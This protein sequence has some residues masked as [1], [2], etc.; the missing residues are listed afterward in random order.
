MDAR[1]RLEQ[2]YASFAPDVRAYARRR[3]HAEAVDDVVADVFVV[4]WRKIDSVPEEALPW[5][6]GVAR[7]VVGNQLR[8][9]HRR[10][11]LTERLGDQPAAAAAEVESGEVLRAL[12]SLSPR[13]REV[14]MLIAWEGL[15]QREA[16]AAMDCSPPVFRVRLFRAR[17]K[18]EHALRQEAADP[19]PAVEGTRTI[20][21]FDK[22]GDLS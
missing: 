8:S 18:L 21:V 2:L 22:R 19:Q 3:I 20:A 7:K 16:A 15:H 14:L 12:A 17:K 6:L 10:L 1:T 5:L 9:A 11:A 4:A 13:D